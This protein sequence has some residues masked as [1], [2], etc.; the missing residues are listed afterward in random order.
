MPDV[1]ACIGSTVGTVIAT[2]K[3]IVRAAVGVDI[4]CGMNAV[5]LTLRADQLPDSLANIRD[6]IE[7][8]VQSRS[9]T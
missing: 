1:Y 5:R 9:R 7:K 3:A 6:A 4:G 8:A 2:D